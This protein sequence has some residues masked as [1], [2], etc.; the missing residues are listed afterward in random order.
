MSARSNPDGKGDVPAHAHTVRLFHETD[1]GEVGRS[2]LTNRGLTVI[3]LE[4]RKK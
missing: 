4:Q 2:V 1:G 3:N